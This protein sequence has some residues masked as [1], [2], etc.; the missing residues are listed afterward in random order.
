[1]ELRSQGLIGKYSRRRRNSS[2]LAFTL[3]ELLVVIPSSDSSALLAPHSVCPEAA[4]P[5][6]CHKNP[7]KQ[8]A[9][10]QNHVSA[11]R[12]FPP[13]ARRLS[14]IEDYVTNGQQPLV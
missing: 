1:M 11:Q 8:M 12:V 14:F 2:Q 13:A 7:L 3:V 5:H 10:M 6:Q 4:P 9:G